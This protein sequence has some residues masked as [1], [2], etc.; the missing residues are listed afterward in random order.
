MPNITTTRELTSIRFF[1]SEPPI[2]TVN[3]YHNVSFDFR[4]PAGSQDANINRVLLG[5]IILVTGTGIGRKLEATDTLTAN[6]SIIGF[7]QAITDGLS[8]NNEYS[9]VGDKTLASENGKLFT[10]DGGNITIY[11]GLKSEYPFD[12]REVYIHVNN[13]PNV[14]VNLWGTAGANFDTY[15]TGAGVLAGFVK[16]INNDNNNPLGIFV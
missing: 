5:D 7:V 16:L 4:T 13:T 15:C 6:K 3:L 11:K 8:V 14:R 9:Y 12:L 1:P 10:A 2:G